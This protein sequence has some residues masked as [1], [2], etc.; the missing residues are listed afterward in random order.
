MNS[1]IYDVS[2][3]SG[4]SIA[5]V[6]RAF[7]NPDRVRESTRRKV[8]EAA[9][10]LHYSPN[11]I[12]QAMA[13]QRT[14]KIAFLICKEGASILDEFYAGICNGIMGETN[15]TDY[16]LVISTAADWDMAANTSKNK[17]V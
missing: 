2:R 10:V 3:L 15:R 13:R 17:Q 7:S 12:A 14:D 6:S 9:E 11:A 8:F 16:E 1:T 4:V 5:T